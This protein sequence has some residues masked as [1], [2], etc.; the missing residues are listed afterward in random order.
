MAQ[1]GGMS[2]RKTVAVLI[3]AGGIPDTVDALSAQQEIML[4]AFLAQQIIPH[5]ASPELSERNASS[6]YP[7]VYVYCGK[8]VNL[9]REKFR[10]FSGTA[11]MIVEA[12]VSLDRLEE[13][14]S[15]LQFYADA[16]TQVLDSNRG[17]WGDGVFY[18]GG[19][20]VTFGGVKHGGR[21]FI[22]IAKVTFTLE[23]STD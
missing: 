11:Q 20:E 14:E 7:L 22:Q 6:K 12:R 19:Y 16:I 3:A 13:M 21:N 15:H 2:T 17:D 5:N 23:I 9:L 1:I 8:I 10:R 18:G 4:P